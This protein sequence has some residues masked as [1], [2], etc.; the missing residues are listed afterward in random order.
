MVAYTFGKPDASWF[1]KMVND[2]RARHDEQCRRQIHIRW[3]HHACAI[4]S[5]I[6]TDFSTPLGPLSMFHSSLCEPLI[7]ELSS[8]FQY[9]IR[10]R[11]VSIVNDRARR[12]ERYMN[13]EG[14]TGLGTL[15]EHEV[16]RGFERM[17]GPSAYRGL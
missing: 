8:A 2:A 15:L 16:I 13:V 14:M 9:P 11:V 10:L 17:A 12:I 1:A 3:G 7:A 5:Q 6:V 4:A